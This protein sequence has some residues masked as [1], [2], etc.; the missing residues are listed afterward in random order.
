MYKIYEKNDRKTKFLSYCGYNITLPSD[1]II[2]ELKNDSE[3]V[4][5]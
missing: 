4:V 5:E 1:F 3:C 2:E